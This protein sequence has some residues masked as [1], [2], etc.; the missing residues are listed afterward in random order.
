MGKRE[1]KPVP[2][3]SEA[4]QPGG[5]QREIRIGK[6]LRRFSFRYLREDG[7]PG[8]RVPAISRERLL[9]F[10]QGSAQAELDQENAR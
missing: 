1:Q 7:L 8:G 4:S 5:K 2:S 9:E 6:G 10:Y 3:I